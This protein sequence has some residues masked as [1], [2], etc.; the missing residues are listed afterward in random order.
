[1]LTVVAGFFLKAIGFERVPVEN[2]L[3]VVRCRP[4]ESGRLNP[5]PP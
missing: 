3:L 5:A 2:L 1:M 4:G